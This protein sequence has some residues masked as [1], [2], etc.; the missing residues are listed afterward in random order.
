MAQW[1]KNLHAIQ[2]TQEMQARSLGPLKEEM[3]SHSSILAM[4]N[5]MDRKACPSCACSVTHSVR[6]F[7]TPWTAARQ[8]PL[9]YGIFPRMN[10]GVGCHASR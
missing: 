3:A 5:S 1:I 9:V 10:T 7:E 8:A 6:L 2:E 4:K